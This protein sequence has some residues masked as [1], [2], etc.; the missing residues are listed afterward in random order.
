MLEVHASNETVRTWKDFFVH[1]AAISVGLL[2]A[3]GLEQSVETLHRG[4]ERA[5]LREDLHTESRQVLADSRRAETAHLYELNWLTARISQVRA[6]IWEGHP[7]GARELNDMPYYASP[8]TP[9]WRSAKAGARTPLLTKGEVNAYAEV[10]YVQTHVE[11]LD[12]AK[13][14][15]ES[16][17][18]SF[19]REFPALLNGDPDLSKASAQDLHTYLT[20]L[21]TTYEAVATYI[22]WIRVLTG[23]ELAIIDGKTNL[24]DIYASERTVANGDI[25]HNFM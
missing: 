16:G 6:A 9:I 21:T 13:N 10:E 17:I 1:I 19:N 14:T 2:I 25:T 12:Y 3:V 4:H 22:H 18:R 15:A 5:A 20:L 23:A 11:A 24:E 7:V 8:D